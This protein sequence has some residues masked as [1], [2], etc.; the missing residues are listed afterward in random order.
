MPTLRW[1]ISP[2]FENLD[3]VLCRQV[4][5]F[6]SPEQAKLF[7]VNEMRKRSP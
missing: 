5:T 6:D 1:M 7:L 4:L 2:H 3:F